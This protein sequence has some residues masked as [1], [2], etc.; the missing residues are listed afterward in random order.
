VAGRLR[1]VQGKY[2]EAE[3]LY[4]E[5]LKKDTAYVPSLNELAWLLA[6][7][8]Q[9][10]DEARE[11]IDRAIELAGPQPSLLDTRAVIELALGQPAKA[12]ADLQA[13][14]DMQPAADRYFHLA[15]AHRK[16]GHTV[17]AAESLKKAEEM[18]LRPETLHP[19][20]RPAYADLVKAA[21]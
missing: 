21:H 7:R 10:L 17:E 1:D 13:V 9:Q 12:L 5:S 8:G 15:L 4:R 6:L 16:L 2:D 20:E 14:I 19:L 18:Q 3:T 11:L